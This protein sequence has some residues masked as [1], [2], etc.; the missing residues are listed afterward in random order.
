MMLPPTPIDKALR[1]RGGRLKFVVAGTK[2]ILFKPI[3]VG[4]GLF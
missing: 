1:L 3:V 4:V 2:V